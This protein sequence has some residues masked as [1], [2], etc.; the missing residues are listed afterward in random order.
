MEHEA[1][2]LES[3]PCVSY[4]CDLLFGKN[5]CLLLGRRHSEGLGIG[6]S[7]PHDIAEAHPRLVVLEVLIHGGQAPVK[8]DLILKLSP[9]ISKDV[10]REVIG[11]RIKHQE[12]KQLVLG[13]LCDMQ[14]VREKT[15]LAVAK[16]TAVLLL[17]R[18]G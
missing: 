4:S 17:Q 8:V 1:C 11:N 9:H 14:P 13:T 18:K 16:G 12:W 7:C 10:S 3:G 2:C 5:R 6:P 15:S